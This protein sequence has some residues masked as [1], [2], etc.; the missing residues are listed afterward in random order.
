MRGLII[1]KKVSAIVNKDYGLDPKISDAISK[2]ADE[3]LSGKIG[4]EHFPCI[5]WTSHTAPNMNANEVLSNRGIQI[6]GGVVGSK[7]PVHPNDHVNMGQSSNDTFP[8]AMHIAV[9]EE[10]NHN[11][12]P[13]LECL[14]DTL[15][16]KCQ[17]F[18]HIIKT[19]RY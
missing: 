2:A 9:A 15:A 16:S 3:V 7:K 4:K 11:L 19:G 14:R 5:I 17:E 18:A 6:L 10:I 1:S 12:L 8:T 13:S